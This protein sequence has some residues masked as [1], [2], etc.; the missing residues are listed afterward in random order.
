MQHL[1]FSQALRCG[2]K[3]GARLYRARLTNLPVI[4]REEVLGYA[5]LSV[6]GIHA[7]TALSSVSAERN[8]ERNA[9]R[10]G[11]S[12]LS[13]LF[14]RCSEAGQCIRSINLLLSLLLG[15]SVG[16]NVLLA[17]R[18][19]QSQ[20]RIDGQPSHEQLQAGTFVPP[21]I[22]KDLEGKSVTVAYDGSN[23][24]TILYVFTPQCV[25]CARNSDNFKALLKARDQDNRFIALSLSDV[26]LQEYVRNYKLTIPVFAGLS[27]EMIS[28]YKLG[29]TPQTVVISPE[30]RV[31]KNWQGAW[32]N[33]QKSDIEAFFHVTL[34]GIQLTTEAP[35]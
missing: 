3:Q 15:T 28:A 16:L 6:T 26:G 7:L 21:I 35:H 32:I 1:L 5:A 20:S 9:E 14:S 12:M 29:G 25:W 10:I 2:R 31:V 4:F 19:R 23:R 30:G 24:T 8:V 34:P 27:S 17:H 11:A 13:S 33:K 22:A 18:V